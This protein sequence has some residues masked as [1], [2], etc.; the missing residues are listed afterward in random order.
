[1]GGTYPL[2]HAT[3]RPLSSYSC[4]DASTPMAGSYFTVVESD[5]SIENPG[6]NWFWAKNLPY[7]NATQIQQQVSAKLEQGANLIF[8]VPPNASGVVP[9]AYVQQVA[10]FGAARAATFSDARAALPAPVAAPCASLSVTLPVSGDFDAVLLREDLAGGQVVGSYSLEVQ[11]AGGG[12]AWRALPP[13]AHGRT[14][15]LR[16]L[17]PV[18]LQRNVTALRV[19]CSSDLAPPPSGAASEVEYVN[20]AGQ[21][22][23]AAAA[24]AAAWPCYTGAAAPGGPAYALCP[25]QAAACGSDGG[26]WSQGAPDA[27]AGAGAGAGAALVA[28]RL[29]PDAVVNVDCNSCAQGTHAKVIAN[30]NCHCASGL[31][32][33][34]PDGAIRALACPGMCLSNGTQPGAHASCAGAEPWSAAQVHLVPCGQASGSAGWTQRALPPAPPIATL[35]F[36]GAYLQRSP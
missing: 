12:G 23:A 30:G 33:S 19:N 10:A 1:M 35:A 7:Y 36:V 15:G 29:A 31:A 26:A 8:N 11:D 6:D 2:Y 13:G 24:S 17:Q 32:Y 16:L 27:A 34:A 21:C 22:M 20:A 3:S 9:E 4:T 28:A 25:L 18:G 14:I 5:F